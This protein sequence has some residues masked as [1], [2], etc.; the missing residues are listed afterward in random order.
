MKI[1]LLTYWW[2]PT[3]GENGYIWET[4]REQVISEHGTREEALA[5][6]PDGYQHLDCDGWKEI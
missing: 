5:N 4:T 6:R 1:A 2:N 3:T